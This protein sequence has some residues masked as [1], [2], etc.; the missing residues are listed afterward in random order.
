MSSNR[1]AHN[2]KSSLFDLHFSS[3]GRAIDYYKLA[4]WRK[5]SLFLCRIRLTQTGNLR[6]HP[7]ILIYPVNGMNA[8]HTLIF[9]LHTKNHHE[10]DDFSSCGYWIKRH[11]LWLVWRLLQNRSVFWFDLSLK[12]NLLCTTKFTW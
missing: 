4:M 1:L 7:S 3:C 5:V 10:I 11:N 12:L 8:S 2:T 6:F 9:A